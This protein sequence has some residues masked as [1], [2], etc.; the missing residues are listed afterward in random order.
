MNILTA[1]A[2]LPVIFLMRFI[3]LKDNVEREPVGLVVKTL[4]F[5]VLS[6][7]PTILGETVL[8]GILSSLLPQN[9][10]LFNLL[11]YFICVAL[12]EEF[13]KMMA[14][15]LAVWKNP[16]FNYT[17]D[18]IVYGVAAALGFAAFENIMYVFQGGLATAGVRAITA[19]PGHAVFGLFMG[20][21]LGL[22][23]YLEV[24]GDRSRASY[25]KKMALLVPTLLHG[26]YDFCCST[27]NEIGML[28]FLAFV[29]ILDVVAIKRVKAFQLNDTPIY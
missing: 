13:C 22:A 2:L 24:R 20:M 29:I 19:I 5:G 14:M 15:R 6:V 23:K 27:N 3:Y 17:F 26:F 18:G 7:F 4:I 21:H 10:V 12:V 16:E 8:I 1:A 9:T 28:V 25:H 11:Q